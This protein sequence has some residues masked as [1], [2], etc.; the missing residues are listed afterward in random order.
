MVRRLLLYNKTKLNPTLANAELTA[1]NCD[2]LPNYLYLINAQLKG[3]LGYPLKTNVH[4][5]VL[6]D[7]NQGSAYKQNPIGS[8]T[9]KV[10]KLQVQISIKSRVKGLGN[11]KSLLPPGC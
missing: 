11:V 6:T 7:G 3:S 9:T 10:Q 2:K 5:Q 1:G 8:S 4:Y